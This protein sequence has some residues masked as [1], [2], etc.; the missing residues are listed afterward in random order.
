[1]K[2]T[3]KRTHGFKAK[4]ELATKNLPD[5]VTVNVAG[6]GSQTPPT[7]ASAGS[8]SPP[9]A[10]GP[11]SAATTTPENAGEVTVKVSAESAAKL[12]GQPFQLV[13]REVDS[14][15][16]HPVRYSLTGTSEDNGVPQGYTDLVIESTEQLWLTVLSGAAE[17]K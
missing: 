2:I 1:M 13:L 11:G 17:Q 9:T 3:L 8:Q 16:E 15:K 7:A 14:G 5:G 4:L 12:A 6:P 10:A